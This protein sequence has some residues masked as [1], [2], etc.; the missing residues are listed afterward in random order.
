[1]SD[2]AWLCLLLAT[3]FVTAAV[4]FIALIVAAVIMDRQQ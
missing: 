2:I 1:M 4:I 3:P